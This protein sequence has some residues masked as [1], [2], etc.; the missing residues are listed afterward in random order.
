MGRVVRF[1]RERVTIVGDINGIDMFDGAD[2]YDDHG[3]SKYHIEV[4]C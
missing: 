3:Y 4:Y 2:A 1:I